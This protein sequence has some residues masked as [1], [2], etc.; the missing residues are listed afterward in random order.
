M[1]PL[2]TLTL[3]LTSIMENTKIKQIV[4]LGINPYKKVELRDKYMKNVPPKFQDDYIY[5]DHP[6][7]QEW[8]APN[9]NNHPGTPVEHSSCTYP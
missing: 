6:I 9:K 1:N 5:G 2:K 3:T 8:M 7:F 4:S